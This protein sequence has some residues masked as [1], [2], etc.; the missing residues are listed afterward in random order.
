MNKQIE[1]KS[2]GIDFAHTYDSVITTAATCVANGTVTYTC[3]HCDHSYFEVVPALGHHYI[4]TETQNTTCTQDGTL[5]SICMSCGDSCTET[6]PATGHCTQ[7]VHVDAT[8]TQDGSLSVF[9][10]A[11]ESELSRA[12]IAALGHDLDTQ[13][14]APTCTAEGSITRTC[15]NCAFAQTESVA[16]LLHTYDR[17]GICTSC[18]TQY[19][20]KL[21][22]ESITAQAGETVSV[23]ILAEQN[24][25]FAYINLD[26]LYNTAVLELIAVENGTLFDTFTQG[27]HLIWASAENIDETGMLAVLTFAVK[28]DAAIGSY[29]VAVQCNECVS[30]T[31]EDLSVHT[32]NGKIDLQNRLYGDATGDGAINGKDVTRLLRYL[33]YFDAET[34][35]STVE[36]AI[37]ADA[38]GD[39]AINGKDVTRLMRYLAFFDNTTGES[40]VPLGPTA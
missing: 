34:G 40:T 16:R 23:A 24:S 15:K 9:C 28:E 17:N 10:T 35:T 31:E 2:A 12:V 30:E 4:C 19:E 7:T 13:T 1:V 33:S 37:G 21:S 38:T 6:V 5:T 26:L 39:G 29:T 32:Q 8:C 36:V 27:D 14:T 25:G 20:I 18:G 3:K 11:C 22:V